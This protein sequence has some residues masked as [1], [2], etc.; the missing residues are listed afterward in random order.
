[1]EDKSGIG[2]VAGEFENEEALVSRPE[3]AEPDRIRRAAL[4]VVDLLVVER[5]P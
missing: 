4:G 5:G 2:K 3:Y 1:M